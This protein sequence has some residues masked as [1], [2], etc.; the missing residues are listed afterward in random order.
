MVRSSLATDPDPSPT[1]E[2]ELMSWAAESE[3]ETHD[4][5]LQVVEELKLF[6]RT[7]FLNLYENEVAGQ[8]PGPCQCGGVVVAP[9]R[10]GQ[11]LN[12]TIVKTNPPLLF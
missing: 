10:R 4:T 5:K 3:P 1:V 9:C 8:G 11:G 7:S 12:P 6:V 2:V